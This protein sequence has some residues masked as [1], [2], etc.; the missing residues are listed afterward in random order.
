[1]NIKRLAIT[2]RMSNILAGVGR[3]QLQVLNQRVEARRGVFEQYESAFSDIAAIQ[4]MP[5]PSWSYS[6][7]W[8][9]ACTI[10]PQLSPLTSTELIA[11]L[12]KESIEARPLWKPMHR[13][14]ILC[15]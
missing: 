4:W 12:G 5:E 6:N 3:G 11:A 9:T 1:M 2:T 14:P 15:W 13:Q 7:R 8:L 10:D